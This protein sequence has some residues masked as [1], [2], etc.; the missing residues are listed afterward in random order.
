M[1]KKKRD[2]KK[3]VVYIIVII[4]TITTILLYTPMFSGRRAKKRPSPTPTVRFRPPQG[5]PYSKGPTAPP[6]NFKKPTS[7]LLELPNS[8]STF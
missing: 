6:P 5:T 2:S 3:I 8:T 4:V 1:A 7:S